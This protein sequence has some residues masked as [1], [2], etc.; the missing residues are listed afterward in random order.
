MSIVVSLYDF[1]ATCRPVRQIDIATQ[2]G[3]DIGRNEE[4]KSLMIRL[5]TRKL[6]KIDDKSIDLINSQSL[7]SIES[8]GDELLDFITADDLTAWLASLSKIQ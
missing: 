8:L 3:K 5:L 2:K 1:Q 4:G 7:E 6:G